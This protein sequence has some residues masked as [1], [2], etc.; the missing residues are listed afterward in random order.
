MS[1]TLPTTPLLGE[2]I[3][4]SNRNCWQADTGTTISTE[5]PENGGETLT[6]GVLAALAGLD[7]FILRK[8][9][10]KGEGAM[11]GARPDWRSVEVEAEL[12][13]SLYPHPPLPPLPP[14]VLL[15]LLVVAGG[16]TVVVVIAPGEA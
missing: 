3:L 15:G 1:A 2:M 11:A 8:L 5:E 10:V 14:L 12:F 9:A 7:T 6:V 4:I 13:V 16:L